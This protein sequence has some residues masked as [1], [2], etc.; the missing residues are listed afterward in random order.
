MLTSLNPQLALLVSSLY[1][2]RHCQ[3][4]LDILVLAFNYIM[5]ALCEKHHCL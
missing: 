1:I 4:T 2:S 3:V 5:S